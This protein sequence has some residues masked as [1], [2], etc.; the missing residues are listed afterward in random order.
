MTSRTEEVSAS[1][2]CAAYMREYR[3][4][5]WLEE[6]SCNNVPKRKKL[7]AERKREYRETYKNLS[8]D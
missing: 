3:K 6:D 1:I 4:G 8:A 2:T 7:N 5:W